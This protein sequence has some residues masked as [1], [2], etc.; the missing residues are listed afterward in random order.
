MSGES[1]DRKG[2]KA[3]NGG[4]VLCDLGVCEVGLWG[5]EVGLLGCGVMGM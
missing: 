3:E 1:T 5:Y 2:Q 4:G